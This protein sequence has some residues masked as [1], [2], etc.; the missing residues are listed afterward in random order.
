LLSAEPLVEELEN[1]I[2]DQQICMRIVGTISDPG[3]STQERDD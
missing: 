2:S 1:L 3:R